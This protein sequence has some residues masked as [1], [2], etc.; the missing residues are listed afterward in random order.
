MAL[1]HRQ[2][3]TMALAGSSCVY[4]RRELCK[5]PEVFVSINM[6]SLFNEDSNL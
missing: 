4:F 6:P 1:E 5:S 2:L 3:R